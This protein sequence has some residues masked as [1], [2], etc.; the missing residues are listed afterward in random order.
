M[1]EQI[2]AVRVKRATTIGLQ[3]GGHKD[4]FPGDILTVGKG[5]D[6][7]DDDGRFLVA[8]KKADPCGRD[9]KKKAEKK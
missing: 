5:Q 3:G 6:V 1:A 7:S 9:E 2:E 8:A 4:V